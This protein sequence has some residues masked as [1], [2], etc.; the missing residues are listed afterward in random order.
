M[1]ICQ[2]EKIYKKLS[3]IVL[4]DNQRLGDDGFQLPEIENLYFVMV[5]KTLLNAKTGPM[6]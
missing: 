4:N 6:K 1:K 3:G 5:S 2:G